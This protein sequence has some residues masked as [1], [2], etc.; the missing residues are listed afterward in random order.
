MREQEVSDV[1]RSE[2]DLE[3][4]LS[5]ARRSS[6]DAGVQD[7]QVEAIAFRGEFLGRRANRPEGGQVE[8]YVSDVDGLRES[9]LNRGNC[10]AG[11]A[12]GASGQVDTGRTMVGK[13]EDGFLSKTGISWID[14][15]LLATL[16]GDGASQ[17]TTKY[18]YRQ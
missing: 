12:L 7:Q 4:L 16:L 9:L 18:P 11:F 1:V 13:L 14:R 15:E 10:I 8:Q 3:S 2:L 6:H 17:A 5:D